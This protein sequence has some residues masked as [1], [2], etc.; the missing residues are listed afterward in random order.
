MP[1]ILVSNR[2]LPLWRKP[3]SFPL[4]GI[5]SLRQPFR[6]HHLKSTKIYESKD[7]V[8]TRSRFHHIG[9]CSLPMFVYTE[10]HNLS[11]IARCVSVTRGWRWRG[12]QVQDCTECGLLGGG[13][14]LRKPHQSVLRC[15]LMSSSLPLI[16][17]EDK[18]NQ[19]IIRPL[20]GSNDPARFLSGILIPAD[21]PRIEF[22][23]NSVPPPPSPLARLIGDDARTDVH[24]A[25]V[26]AVIRLYLGFWEWSSGSRLLDDYFVFNHFVLLSQVQLFP[27]LIEKWPCVIECFSSNKMN[28]FN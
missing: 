20:C 3:N 4:K 17:I 5:P 7:Y 23:L 11:N 8:F 28:V 21:F 22:G 19:R 24:F 1:L 6:K 9:L 18:F 27:L 13:R 25:C 2:N 14:G 15:E 16:E 12:V 10:Q 26:R